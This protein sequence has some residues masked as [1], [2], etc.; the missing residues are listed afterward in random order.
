[1][2]PQFIWLPSIFELLLEKSEKG[3]KFMIP[4]HKVPTVGAN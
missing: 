2:A 1:M 4:M 3:V